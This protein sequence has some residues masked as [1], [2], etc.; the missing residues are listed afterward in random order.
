MVIKYF[1]P[2]RT[3]G[4]FVKEFD[5]MRLP[6]NN[7]EKFLTSLNK[8]DCVCE[9][10]KLVLVDYFSKRDIGEESIGLIDEIDNFENY[11]YQSICDCF[12]EDAELRSF[13]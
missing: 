10:M 11:V 9:T 13:D 2:R 12:N 7:Y 6:N 5:Y 3:D 8:I 1:Y 4:V